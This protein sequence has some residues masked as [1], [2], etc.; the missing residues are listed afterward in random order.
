MKFC[1]H[2]HRQRAEIVY[3][4]YENAA[5]R[6]CHSVF[7]HQEAGGGWIKVIS[8][9]TFGLST[10]FGSTTFR[11]EV[12]GFG[13]SNSGGA[14]VVQRKRHVRIFNW[15]IATTTTSA[16]QPGAFR[17]NPIRRNRFKS[18]SFNIPLKATLNVEFDKPS[19][20]ATPSK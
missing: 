18:N 2:L 13:I 20:E 3:A 4:Q 11:H 9:F 6:P 17:V 16:I 14:T 8:K 12:G 5:M 10:G 1:S 19:A 7:L 15:F